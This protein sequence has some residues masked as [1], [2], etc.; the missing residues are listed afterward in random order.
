MSEGKENVYMKQ[1]IK[2]WLSSSVFFFSCSESK[3]KKK[4]TS[5][6]PVLSISTD[7]NIYWINRALDSGNIRTYHRAAYTH[8]IKDNPEPFLYPAIIMANKYD[9]PNAYYHVY[10]VL[11]SLR[12]SENLDSLD[13]RTKNL[14]LHYL[15]LAYEKGQESAKIEALKIFGNEAS[16]PKSSSFLLKLAELK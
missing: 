7:S 13:H 6:V 8:F 9:N 15:V 4:D 1:I 3:N 14:A 2:L 11:N 5:V 12:N 16:I 10:R